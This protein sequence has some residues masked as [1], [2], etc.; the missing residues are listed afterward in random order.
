MPRVAKVASKLSSKWTL[1]ATIKVGKLTNSI[2]LAMSYRDLAVVETQN[3]VADCR[4]QRLINRGDP[5]TADARYVPDK[6]G[7]K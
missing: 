7:R 3:V 4:W 5:N 1:A 6:S 2:W